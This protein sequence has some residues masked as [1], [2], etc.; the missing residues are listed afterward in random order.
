MGFPRRWRRNSVGYHPPVP[1][2][3]GDRRHRRALLKRSV[4]LDL[5]KSRVLLITGDL[6]GARMAGPAIRVWNF[7]EQLA[8]VCDVRVVSWAPIERTADDFE[9]VFVH[10]A[11]DTAM[12]EHVTDPKTDPADLVRAVLDATERD[13]YE[14]LADEISVQVKA[15]L[16]APL[17][18]VYPQLRAN[19]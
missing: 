9:L 6:I 17:E 18:A 7:A 1:P 8:A 10:E 19:A 16:S 4:V 2:S 3:D 12:A 5:M 11:D 15:G 13:E 14:V